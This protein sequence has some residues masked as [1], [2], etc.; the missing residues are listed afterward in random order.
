MPLVVLKNGETLQLPEGTTQ[1]Q[2]EGIRS[3]IGR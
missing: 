3:I 2:I 1:S